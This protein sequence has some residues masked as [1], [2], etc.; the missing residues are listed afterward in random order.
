VVSF[1]PL[2]LY[3]QIESTLYLLVRR[4]GGPQ[5][6]SGRGSEEKN[7]H[8]LPGHEPP[9]FQPVALR[10]TTELSRFLVEWFSLPQLYSASDR[11]CPNHWKNTPS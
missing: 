4:L 7:S 3:P 6:Q 11:F 2:S 9:I 1:T 8:T 5:S 10:Y